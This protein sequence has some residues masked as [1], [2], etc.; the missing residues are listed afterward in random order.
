MSAIATLT[1]V[2]P[3][4]QLFHYSSLSGYLG[5]VKSRT[6]WASNIHRLSDAEEY[7]YGLRLTKQLLEERRL[8]TT[9]APE[10]ELLETLGL[11][12]GSIV[13][14]NLF[15]VSFSAND[16][17][18]SQW[19]GYCP[20]G[21]GVSIGF[22][23]SDLIAAA[24]RQGFRLLRVTYKLSEAR[25]IAGELIS[26]A[27]RKRVE[28]ASRA[29]ADIASEFAWD[30]VSIA[31]ALKH[32]AFAEESEWRLVSHMTSIH[33][34]QLAVRESGGNLYTFFEFQLAAASN[35]LRI[36]H[37]RLGP[38]GTGSRSAGAVFD[39][40]NIY[41]VDYQGVMPSA[42]PYRE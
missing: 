23:S 15:V 35:S 40:L 25:A 28:N 4:E 12:L 34:P 27:L 38:V 10:I 17:L 32:E 6:L 9:A 3:P 36:G 14:T 13:R 41:H 37:V 24:Q 8:L 21:K 22:Y 30:F 2:T 31:P 1:S 29:S 20:N 42:I 39:A 5:I 19:R 18:L 7:A 11:H 16:D 33:H 26:A